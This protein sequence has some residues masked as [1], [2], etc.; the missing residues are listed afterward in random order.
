MENIQLNNDL[1]L[2]TKEAEDLLADWSEKASCYRWLHDRCE[3]NIEED[4]IHFQ[5]Q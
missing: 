1:S 2:W 5:F 3:K 4:I